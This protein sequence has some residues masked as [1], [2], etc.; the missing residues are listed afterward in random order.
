MKVGDVLQE[1]KEVKKE[2]LLQLRA[3]VIAEEN[4]P[5]AS[6]ARHGLPTCLEVID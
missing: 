6:P 3:V 4:G 1:K 2:R 5:V